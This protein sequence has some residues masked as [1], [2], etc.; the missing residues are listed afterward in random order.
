MHPDGGARASRRR[1]A[2]D[3]PAHAGQRDEPYALLDISHKPADWI[4]ERFPGSDAALPRARLRPDGR[5]RARRARRAL[6]LRRR[7]RR[8]RRPDD[9]GHLRAVGEVSCTGVHGANRLASTSLLEGLLWGWRAGQGRGARGSPDGRAGRCRPCGRGNPSTSRSTRRSSR[10]TGWSSVTRCGTTSGCC[11][12]KTA[13]TAR[14][15]SSRELQAEIED[16]YRRG[17]MSDDLVG[18]RNGVQTALA[19][20]RAADGQPGLPAAAITGKTDSRGRRCP[21]AGRR[22]KPRPTTFVRRPLWAIVRLPMSVLYLHFEA[23]ER[24]GRVQKLAKSG[25][26]VVVS[27]PAGRASSSK[28]RR[29]S[30]TPSPSTSPTRPPTPW[31]RPTTSPRPRRRATRPSTCCAFPRIALEAVKKRLPAAAVVTEPELGRAPGAAEK[32]AARRPSRRRRPP[33]PPA[34][35]AREKKKAEQPGP[36]SPPRPNREA[37]SEGPRLEDARRSAPKK[38]SP[39]KRPA[40]KKHARRSSTAAQVSRSDSFARTARSLPSECKRGALRC[41]RRSSE[42]SGRR[43]SVAKPTF[44]GSEGRGVL[45]RKTRACTR[46]EDLFDAGSLPGPR[47]T[48]APARS[49]SDPRRRRCSRPASSPPRRH[50]RLVEEPVE[51]GVERSSGGRPPAAAAPPSPGIVRKDGSGRR[52]PAN[53]VEGREIVPGQK[54]SCRARGWRPRTLPPP[55]RAPRPAA[56]TPARSSASS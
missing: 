32:E 18:L 38:K 6:L 45:T 44:S 55:S 10:R 41:G 42:A 3:P 15:G 4:R 19:I 1:G 52:V 13:W 9:L 56:P 7:R 51:V 14:H 39:K 12:R 21:V 35:L 26:H 46:A 5:T 54:P 33:P 50:L 29:K 2:R 17:E 22:E 40:K 16:F 37:E 25:A 20:R 53:P 27:S 47:R 24:D 31:K 28:P 36:C 34:R 8:R 23:P 49:G 43:R 30:R 48:S 11:A